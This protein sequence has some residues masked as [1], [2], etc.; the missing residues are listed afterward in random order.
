MH[1][2]KCIQVGGYS[3]AVKPQALDARVYLD[4]HKEPRVR[5]ANDKNSIKLSALKLD[6]SSVIN[7][8]RVRDFA[9]A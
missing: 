9:L 8:W 7:P 6:G 2:F 3:R 5:F 4:F 1:A